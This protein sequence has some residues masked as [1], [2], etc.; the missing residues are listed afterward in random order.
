MEN[1]VILVNLGIYQDYTNDN[2]FN[3]LKY[4]NNVI[5]IIDENLLQFVENKD[6]IKIIKTSEL[7]LTYFEKRNRLNTTFRQGFWKNCSK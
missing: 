6:K 7:D 4:G 3:L 5:L 2:I 1:Q